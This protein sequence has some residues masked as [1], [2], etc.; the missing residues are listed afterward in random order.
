MNKKWQIYET[1]EVEIEK[2][3]KKYNINKLLSS[4]LINR[5]IKEEEIEVFLNPTRQN[6]HDPFLM[7]DMDKAVERIIRAIENQEKIIIYGDYDVD[8][9]TSI[10][11]LKSFL[12]DR[13]IEVDQ[14]IPNRLEEG[15][16]LNKPAIDEI[17]KN[18]YKLMI[19]VD[20]GISGIEEIN[21][22]NSIRNRNNSN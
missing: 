19:T 3:S 18:N 15:Y 17:A 4:I 8:G 10:T 21:Y 16:G 9:I 7:P 6:F 1:D 2:I 13:G 12:E 5:R 14:Y 11:V 22:A 20:C